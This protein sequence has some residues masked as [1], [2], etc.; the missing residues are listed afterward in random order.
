MGKMITFFDG[1]WR[2]FRPLVD[3]ERCW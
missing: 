2:L 3:L 1:D